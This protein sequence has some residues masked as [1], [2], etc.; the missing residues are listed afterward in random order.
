MPDS[1]IEIAVLSL[2]L[3]KGDVDTQVGS[4]LKVI[5]LTLIA[6]APLGLLTYMI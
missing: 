2:P 5:A 6:T 3:G 1:W 4:A